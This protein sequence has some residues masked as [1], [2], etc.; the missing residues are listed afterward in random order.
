MLSDIE[1]V[2][3]LDGKLGEVVTNVYVNCL[4]YTHGMWFSSV[5]F[6]IDDM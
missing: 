2:R 1:Y 6:D 5:W 3:N 4:S